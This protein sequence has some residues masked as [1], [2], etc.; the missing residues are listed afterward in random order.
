MYYFDAH[1][2]RRTSLL[3][4]VTFNLNKQRTNC[5]IF[6]K[7]TSENELEA[8]VILKFFSIVGQTGSI[9]PALITVLPS[10]F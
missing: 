1:A 5:K 6:H 3:T 8:K 9:L 10:L 7:F 2:Y 4:L